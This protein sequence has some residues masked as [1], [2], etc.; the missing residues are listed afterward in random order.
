LT[1]VNVQVNIKQKSLKKYIQ[2]RKK[3]E[4]AFAEGCDEGYEQFKIGVVFK[5]P[6]EKAGLMQEELAQR[7]KTK[8]A[9]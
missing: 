4:K 9:I 6:G 3:G 2:E 1:K 7:L 8:T 5:Q